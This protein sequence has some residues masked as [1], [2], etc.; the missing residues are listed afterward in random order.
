LGYFWLFDPFADFI[1]YGLLRDMLIFR[2]YT[3][4]YTILLYWGIFF[5]TRIAERNSLNG[6]EADLKKMKSGRSDYQ[7][8]QTTIGQ[9]GE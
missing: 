2:A 8:Y 5:V 9:A 4:L 6:F 1:P 7:Q 3:F